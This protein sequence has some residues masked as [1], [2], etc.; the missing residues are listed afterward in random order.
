MTVKQYHAIWCVLINQRFKDPGFEAIAEKLKCAKFD[1]HGEIK[2]GR[3][4]ERES[5]HC[6]RCYVGR[7]FPALWREFRARVQAGEIP[8]RSK[9]TAIEHHPESRQLRLDRANQLRLF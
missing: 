9:R 3:H 6:V 1:R 7:H 5:D 2:H 8:A 4:N